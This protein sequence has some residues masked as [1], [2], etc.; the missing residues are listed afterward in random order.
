MGCD[1]ANS[2][3]KRKDPEAS[4]AHLEKHRF[5]EVKVRFEISFLSLV[6]NLFEECFN[7]H[8]RVRRV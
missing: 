8:E 2:T 4:D 7:V 1:D 6:L 5:Q 3:E